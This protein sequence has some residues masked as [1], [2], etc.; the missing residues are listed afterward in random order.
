MRRQGREEPPPVSADDPFAALAGF[1]ALSS[2]AREDLERDTRTLVADVDDLLG[3][4][5]TARHV[6][7]ADGV[8]VVLGPDGR[9][10][11]LLGPGRP[12]V[13]NA[14]RT[15]QALRTSRLRVLP[16]RTDAV[17]ARE[18][19]S[20]PP[21][22]RWATSVG[23]L[24]PVPG[25]VVD[26]SDPADVVVGRLDAAGAPAAAVT[27]RHAPAAVSRRAA[28]R[29]GDR[30]VG[31]VAVEGP[32]VA[33]EAPA[34][35]ALT[36]MITSGVAEVA[37]TSGDAPIGALAVDH[38]PLPVGPA[39]ASACHGDGTDGADGRDLDGARSLSALATPLARE[40]LDAGAEAPEI[41]RALAAVTA[42]VV[43]AC[44][45][46]S[47]ADLGGAPTPYAWLAFGSLARGETLPDSDLDTGL[48]WDAD[49][50]AAASWAEQ[51]AA[52][53]TERLT[54]LGYRMD[55]SG[56]TATEA[57]W[58]RSLTGWRA[59]VDAWTDPQRRQELLGVHLA[60]DVLRV[61]GDLAADEELQELIRGSI[62]TSAT[63]ATLTEDAIRRSAPL[64]LGRRIGWR[65]EAARR[66]LD[67]KRD[68]TAPIVELARM[69]T[70]VRGGTEL[71]T[72]ERLA[73]AALDRRL[74]PLLA[75]RLRDGFDLATRVR[76][77]RSVDRAPPVPSAELGEAL[78]PAIR[79]LATAQRGLRIRHAPAGW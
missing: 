9:P 7:V 30:A 10:Q 64:L 8:L 77:A 63:M 35:E 20:V 14:T 37:L 43:A 75:L 32:P 11:D 19:R 61:A 23:R 46:R 69:H 60:V 24:V 47:V 39:A 21:R 65:F 67:L 6:A 70:L 26:A 55:P 72:L 25:V 79:A 2:A 52:T 74:D 53:T 73:A 38:F 5:V 76:L 27:G 4:D 22:G 48:A 1:A 78:A 3:E 36:A 68:V 59:A 66:R 45:A 13:P 18:V 49:T 62:G 29:A 71:A 17:L 58:R 56:V 40:L 12:W 44:V 57:A 28:A 16:G 42:R 54:G 15:L 50:P 41:A 33:I 31:E 34:V 51:L